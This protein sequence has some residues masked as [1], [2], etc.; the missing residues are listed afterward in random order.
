M[1][2]NTRLPVPTLPFPGN[3]VFKIE[4]SSILLKMNENCMIRM[5]GLAENE[6][7]PVIVP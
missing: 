2:R 7:S 3:F 6:A 5:V 1:T 4:T